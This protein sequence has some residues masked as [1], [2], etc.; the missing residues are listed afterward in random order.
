[1]KQGDLFEVSGKIRQ[2]DLK[3]YTTSGPRDCWI[4]LNDYKLTPVVKEEE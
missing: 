4:L 3:T 1:M 2:V